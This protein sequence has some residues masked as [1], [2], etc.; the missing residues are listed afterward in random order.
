MLSVFVARLPPFSRVEHVDGRDKPGHDRPRRQPC[1]AGE[2]L[3]SQRI[4][5]MVNPN[6]ARFSREIRRARKTARAVPRT[7]GGRHGRA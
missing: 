7:R 1:Q 5:V 3:G 4:I 2:G 6:N